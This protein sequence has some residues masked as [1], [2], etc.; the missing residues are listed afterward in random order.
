[1]RKFTWLDLKKR[2]ADAGKVHEKRR[3]QKEE[4]MFE[5]KF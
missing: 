1:M 5:F 4:R 2:S 3:T